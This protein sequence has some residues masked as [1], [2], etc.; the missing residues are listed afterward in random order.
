VQGREEVAPEIVWGFWTEVA[1][2]VSW[3]AG[4]F[5]LEGVYERPGGDEDFIDGGGIER[6]WGG[7]DMY[8]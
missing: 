7:E 6:R 4:R 2:H 1:R 5:S 3:L 8:I